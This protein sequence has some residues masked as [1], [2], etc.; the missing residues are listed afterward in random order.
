MNFDADFR[1]VGV[2]LV[3]LVQPFAYLSRLH[4]NYGIISGCVPCGT[5][6]KVHSYCAFF[7]PLVVPLQAVVDYVSQK[8]LAALAR[9]KNGTAQDRVEF[10]KDRGFFRFFQDAVIAIN[11]FA[12]QRARCRIHGTYHLRF[13]SAA[14]KQALAIAYFTLLCGDKRPSCYAP[15]SGQPE[16]RTLSPKNRPSFLSC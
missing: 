16:L 5:L 4:P 3:I 7:E 8:L 6:E 10:A 12:P 9:V 11:F 14:T 2:R 15:A 13:E 1:G